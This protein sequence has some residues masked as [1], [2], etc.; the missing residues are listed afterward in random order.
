VAIEETRL[1]VFDS[2]RKSYSRNTFKRCGKAQIRKSIAESVTTF[3]VSAPARKGS[4]FTGE[5]RSQ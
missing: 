3:Y 1:Q 4:I 2:G 5:N